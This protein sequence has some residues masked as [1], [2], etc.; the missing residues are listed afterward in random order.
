MAD[1]SGPNAPQ[2]IVEPMACL[3]CAETKATAR[4]LEQDNKGTN[5]D[6]I[7]Y[8]ARERRNGT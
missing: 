7:Y 5:T 8:V 4:A 3:C 2:Y 6:G 1:D